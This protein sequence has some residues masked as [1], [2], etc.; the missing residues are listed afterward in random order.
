MVGRGV[1]EHNY[2]GVRMGDWAWCIRTYGGVRMG[3]RAWCIRT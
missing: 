2:D 1:L 3:V